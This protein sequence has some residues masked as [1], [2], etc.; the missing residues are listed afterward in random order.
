MAE[1]RN[2]RRLD[3]DDMNAALHL[4]GATLPGG[5]LVGARDTSAR[6]GGFSISYPVTGPDGRRGFLKVLDLVSV[7]GDLT[8]LSNTLNDFL[9]ERDL[10]LLCGATAMSRVVVA[11]DHGQVTLDAY[12]PP[13]S[14]VHYIVF[15][16]A[17][18][19]DLSDALSATRVDDLALRLD[20]I[21]DLAVGLR[22]LHAKNIAHQDVKP[23]NSLIFHRDRGLRS[24]G[25]VSD[26]GRAYQSGVSTSHDED[27][28]P[29]DRSFAPP[30]QLYGFQHP[31]VA[32]RRFGADLYQLGSLIC[33]T[34]GAVTFNAMLAERLAPEHHWSVFGDGFMNALP[35]IDEAFT[36]AIRDLR[37]TLPREVSPEVVSLIEYLCEPR[38]ER[39]GHPRARGKH[40]SPFSLERVVAE[41]N[42]AAVRARLRSRVTS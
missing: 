15:E 11:I 27:L 12:M 30:E 19:G 6:A 40:G 14:T 20:L 16:H 13:L 28:I 37:D 21:H 2:D 26:L 8:D 39:R 34:I 41:I 7:F 42:L 32:T 31:D 38:P 33:F 1:L 10:V 9:I 23:D 22:Q 25:K 24:I 17:E 4:E 36:D 5:W 29:G 35:Y 18:G 3:M